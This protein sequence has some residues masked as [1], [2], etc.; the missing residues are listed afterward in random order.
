MKLKFVNMMFMAFLSAYNL[1]AGSFSG[2]SIDDLIQN[3][4][5]CHRMAFLSYSELQNKL[6]EVAIKH[7][8]SFNKSEVYIGYVQADIEKLFHGKDPESF[9][10][11]KLVKILSEANQIVDKELNRRPTVRPNDEIEE[12]KR[13][14]DSMNN[15]MNRTLIESL[16][17]DWPEN[18]MKA[19]IFYESFLMPGKKFYAM[20]A[21]EAFA[22]MNAGQETNGVLKRLGKVRR[23]LEIQK[24]FPAGIQR[25]ARFEKGIVYEDRM[26]D[27]MIERAS[28]ILGAYD[29]MVG[30]E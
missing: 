26:L 5:K 19:H 25:M 11:P 23:Y 12:E 2:D 30:W 3:P 24:R 8:R 15:A 18:S 9:P 27:A 4:A 20:N 17:T 16:P 10:G 14:V 1:C 6:V 21:A 7:L 28:A 29:A 13:F 22:I